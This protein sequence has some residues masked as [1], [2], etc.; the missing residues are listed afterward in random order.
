MSTKIYL[1]PSNQTAN[2]GAYKDTNEHEQCERIAL[3]AKKYLEA[4][5]ECEVKVAERT[6]TMQK[7]A[8]DAKMFGAEVYLP[9]HTNAFNNKTVR[10]TETFYHSSDAKGKELAV[11]L[12]NAISTITGVKRR[13]KAYDGLYELSEPD[14]TRAQ[15]RLQTRWLRS[16]P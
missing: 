14:C 16:V 8:D 12:L 6:D 4:H 15:K 9:I 11:Q 2:V 13:A 3:A 1:S 7:R 10:G 5:Y